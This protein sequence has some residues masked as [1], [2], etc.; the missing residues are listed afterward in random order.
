M[1]TS[2]CSVADRLPLVPAFKLP[3]RGASPSALLSSSPAELATPL[4]SAC[5]SR[6]PISVRRAH[7]TVH[8]CSERSG[9]SATCRNYSV[10]VEHLMVYCCCLARTMQ[11]SLVV[12]TPTKSSSDVDLAGEDLSANENFVTRRLLVSTDEG[13]LL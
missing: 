9:K 11:S 2:T 8:R 1:Q 7:C 12:W 3:P 13:T 4:Q 6:I 10:R 5:R